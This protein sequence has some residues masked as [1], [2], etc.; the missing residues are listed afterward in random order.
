MILTAQGRRRAGGETRC[1]FVSIIGA[2]N[3]GKSTLT[4]ALV[5]VKVSI[6]SHKV[7]TTRAQ[8][9]GIAL[10]GA[11]PD[12]PGRHARHFP[13]QAPARPGDGRCR[14]GRRAR[15]RC[16]G[17]AG[18]CRQGHRRGGRG[19]PRRLQASSRCR[20]ALALNKMDRIRAKIGRSSSSWPSKAR[21]SASSTE[22]FMISARDGDGVKDLKAYLAATR[23]AGA[24]ALSGRP[25][26]R[27]AAAPLG[28][29]GD[30]REDLSAP[31]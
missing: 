24:L 16:G 26:Q 5:G 13:A 4:N 28:R 1:G 6:V 9:R 27:R 29:R 23:A 3:A 17:G 10:S 15:G 21:R 19:D 20:C 11:E 2:P 18:R 12:H 25:D 31:A 22:A 7:Q 8:I 14:L 30:A